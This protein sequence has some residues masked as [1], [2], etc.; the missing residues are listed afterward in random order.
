MVVALG[1][2][3]RF[4]DFKQYVDV[5][6]PIQWSQN[7]A[8]RSADFIFIPFLCPKDDSATFLAIEV[9]RLEEFKKLCTEIPPNPAVCYDKP[10]NTFTVTNEF[11][12]GQG[13]S[14]GSKFRFLVF[15]SSN[16]KPYQHRFIG[17]AVETLGHHAD[18]P[19]GVPM[20]HLCTF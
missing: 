6:K 13:K 3:I 19:R 18:V 11:K 2:T 17:T 8:T 5:H 7:F 15:L 4:G 10:S 12:Y 20:D 14:H 1:D 9:G 16:C